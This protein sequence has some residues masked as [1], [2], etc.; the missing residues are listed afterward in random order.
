MEPLHDKRFTLL[1]ATLSSLASAAAMIH[2]S[3]LAALALQMRFQSKASAPDYF[4]NIRDMIVKMVTRLEEEQTAETSKSDWCGE[5]LKQ[6]KNSKDDSQTAHDDAQTAVRSSEAMLAQLRAD[7][8]STQKALAGSQKDLRELKTEQGEKARLYADM[9]QE[10]V[11]GEAALKEAV[12][13]LKGIY[14]SE[15]GNWRITI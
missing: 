3:K 13:F 4:V 7:L 11:A 6:M 12:A 14:A 15:V 5:T 9:K 2:S 1:H 8:K 10:K